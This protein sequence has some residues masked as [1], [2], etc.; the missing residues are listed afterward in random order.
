[1][2][3]RLRW[4]ALHTYQD[5]NIFIGYKINI[6]TMNTSQEK[7]DYLLERAMKDKTTIDLSDANLSGANL[8]KAYLSE[9]NLS[10]ARLCG[11]DLSGAIDIS[12]IN[13]P[14]WRSC[15]LIEA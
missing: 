9:A 6:F 2:R 3:G 11:A 10:E 7:L 14:L 13:V 1:V 8:I 15:A 5:Y 4:L 12:I